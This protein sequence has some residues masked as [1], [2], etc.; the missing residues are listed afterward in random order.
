MYLIACF[1]HIN[2]NLN[3]VQT[4]KVSIYSMFFYLKLILIFL[5]NKE[6]IPK[7]LVFRGKEECK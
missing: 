6:E 5:Y 1:W 4:Y 3:K 2:F 7:I